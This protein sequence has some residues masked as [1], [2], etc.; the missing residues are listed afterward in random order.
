M[1]AAT[2]GDYLK[3][4]Y[5]AEGDE[6]WYH[7]A[8]Y[9]V[10]SND[11]ITMALNEYGKTT[12]GWNN[13]VIQ[14]PTSDNYQFVF[15]TGTWDESQGKKAGASMSIDNIRAENPYKI[16]DE[17]IQQLLRSTSYSSSS[18]NQKYVKE[19][20][21]KAN[22]GTSEISDTSKIFNTEYDNRLMVA[23]TLNLEKPVSFGAQ[24]LWGRVEQQIQ[25]LSYQKL[26]K[27]KPALARQKLK[28]KLIMLF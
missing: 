25:L 6:D 27:F 14:V 20:S 8:A 12:N 3:L 11:N 24:I 16:T 2:Q 13:L 7:V 15:I 1:F 5:K 4:D 18:D 26:K 19:V 21:I 23:P 17:V 22:D 10:D 9:L 28:Q